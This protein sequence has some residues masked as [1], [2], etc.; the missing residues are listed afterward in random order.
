MKLPK[1]VHQLHLPLQSG[2]NDILRKMNR[3]YTALQYIEVIKKVRQA[4][5]DIKLS[6]KVRQAIPDI[7]LSTDVIV[8]F[9]GETKKQFQNTVKLCQQIGFSKAYINK[10]SPRPGTAAYKMED[11]VPI[12]EKKRRWRI[13]DNLINR[14]RVKI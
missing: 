2:D 13:L 4:I 11:D 14:D 6:K 12:T 7:K 8:G 1:V 5:P 3:P 10:Y 9:P